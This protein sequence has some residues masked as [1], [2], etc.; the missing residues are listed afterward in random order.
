MHAVMC[1]R[2][3]RLGLHPD[4]DV[5]DLLRQSL[6]ETIVLVIINLHVQVSVFGYLSWQ[7]C[8]CSS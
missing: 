4:T 1:G 6:H 2:L 5:V 7:N 8:Q 3:S